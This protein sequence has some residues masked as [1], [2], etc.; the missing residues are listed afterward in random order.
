MIAD[1]DFYVNIPC[2]PSGN[3]LELGVYL[4]NEFS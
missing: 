2:K 3:I 4:L 1:M